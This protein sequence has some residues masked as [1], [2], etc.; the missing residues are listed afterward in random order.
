[1]NFYT[2]RDHG[3]FLKYP[4]ATPSFPEGWEELTPAKDAVL[5]IGGPIAQM[6]VFIREIETGTS[7]DGYVASIKEGYSFWQPE[8]EQEQTID[9]GL[10]IKGQVMAFT[11]NLENSER[12][13]LLV[14]VRGTKA[15]VFA[16]TAPT[17]LFSEAQGHIDLI[18][19]SVG[20]I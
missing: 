4:V 10:G 9:V 18:L 6:Q 17:I 3:F 11:L 16:A 14:V 13:K 1:M 7:L 19:N 12:M 5:H 20:L 8:F 2:N 15:L